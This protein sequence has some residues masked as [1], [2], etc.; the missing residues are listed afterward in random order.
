MKRFALLAILTILPLLSMAQNPD[1]DSISVF[2]FYLEFELTNDQGD[3]ETGDYLKNYG[4]K[5]K[6]RAM[7]YMYPLLNDFF[8]KNMIDKGLPV[9]PMRTC[10]FIKENVYGFPVAAL[11]KAVKSG[12]STR[13]LKISLKDIGQVIPGQTNSTTGQAVKPV[14]IRCRLQ[15]YDDQKVLLKE[16]EAQFQTGEKV[17]SQYNI[18]VNLREYQGG[19]WE[20][21]LKFYEVCFKMA[22]LRALDKF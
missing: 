20:Q 13:Y 18:G 9:R 4:T 15:L 1:T 5:G 12:S 3:L 2:N 17:G 21:E 14:I 22:F 10:S 19:G 6:T 16:S 8:M 7:E 11:P